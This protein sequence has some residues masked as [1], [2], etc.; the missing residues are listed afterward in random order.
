[1]EWVWARA[2]GRQ[3]YRLFDA[4]SDLSCGISQQL[5][6]L[7]SQAPLLAAYGW[8]QMEYGLVDMGRSLPVFLLAYLV[9]DHQYYWWHRAS[10]R[11]N[12]MWAAHVVHHQSEDYNLAVA[13]RQA[14]ITHITS[15]PFYIP[16]AF[17]GFDVFVFGIVYAL[18]TLYQFWIHTELV[19][20]LGP[21][22][23][24]LNTP[25]HHRVHHGIN[26]RY[27]DKNYAG[28]LI[29]WDRLYGTFEE[30]EE[31]VV[32]GITK[33]LNSFN[34]FW[35]NCHYWVELWQ[36]CRRLRRWSDKAYVWIAPPEWR[37]DGEPSPEHWP[38]TPSEQ[39]KFDAVVAPLQTRGIQVVFAGVSLCLVVLILKGPTMLWWDRMAAVLTVYL[40][41]WM[42]TW[43][44][45]PHRG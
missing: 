8:L 45:R 16:L 38:Q 18:N 39:K 2:R 32:F 33:P 35:A 5:F 20:K 17:L 13:L 28:F 15:W 29:T 25:S 44:Q 41:L 9:I 22:E 4:I 14:L 30:E 23:Q 34:P 27:I 19:G 26:G 11:V 37:G 7:F 31:P 12:F 42:I 6:L 3:V 21:L 36:R 10:H 1:M 43:P 40:L 24:V